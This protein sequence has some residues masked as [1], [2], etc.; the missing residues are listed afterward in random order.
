MHPS[1]EG[2]V[3]PVMPQMSA[4]GYAGDT[5]GRWGGQPLWKEDLLRGP[6][7]PEARLARVASCAG[8]L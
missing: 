4:R 2:S 8:V 3:S 6:L 1:A 7:S 5:P